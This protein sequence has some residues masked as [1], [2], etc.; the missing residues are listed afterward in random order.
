MKGVK[1]TDP[2]PQPKGRTAVIAQVIVPGLH[3]WPDAPAPVAF[4]RTPHRH[5]FHIKAKV[6]VT[7]DDRDI[8]FIML[9][10]RLKNYLEIMYG[11]SPHQ[12][13]FSMLVL[14]FGAMSCEA[15]ARDL[16]TEFGLTSCEV[17]EDGENGAEVWA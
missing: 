7:H 5:Q 13:R 10:G 2:K 6:E 12:D 17:Y 9:A 4:L 3:C 15:I 11:Y 1:P 14:D 8:E 16:V